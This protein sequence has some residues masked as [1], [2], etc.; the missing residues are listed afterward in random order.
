MNDPSQSS[1]PSAEAGGTA[2]GNAPLDEAGNQ[3]APARA[4]A[5]F[6]PRSPDRSTD[7]S[8][9]TGRRAARPSLV[10]EDDTIA[11]PDNPVLARIWRDRAVESQHRGIWCLADGSGAVLEGDG[12]WDHPVYTRSSVKCLQALPLFE[13]GA[14]ERFRLTPTEIALAVASHNG[15][16]AH[17]EPV[18]ALLER[19][20]LGPD[21]LL[22]G[23][24]PPG[25]PT[26]KEALRAAGARP[27]TLHNNCSGKHAG[28]LALAKHLGVPTADYI[29]PDSAGQKLIKQAVIDISGVDE[30]QL[31]VAIDG[32]S[33]PTFRMPLAALATAFAR[34]TAPDEDWPT[35]DVARRAACHNML[36]AVAAHPSMIAGEY[37]RLCT[38]IAR[39][40]RGR[41]FPKIGAEGVYAIGV[42]DRRCALAVKID[43]GSRRALHAVVLGLL[44][45]FEL[46]TKPELAALVHWKNARLTN[47]AGLDVGHTEVVV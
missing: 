9:E 23:A 28:F 47:W 18:S 43:D 35:F 27:S 12:A 2:P 1:T 17:T 7:R 37:K 34:V 8:G 45:R 38:D 25:D 10:V 30:R 15:E 42:R 31:S 21:D 16:A 5:R 29:D 11:L 40:T 13:S 3:T 39:V 4:P 36:D 14:A 33:A 24:Q 19:L 6:K 32:C 20:G 46:L 44:E 26:E 22:C 41:L